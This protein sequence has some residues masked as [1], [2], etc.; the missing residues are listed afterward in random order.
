MGQEHLVTRDRK[1]LGVLLEGLVSRDL[2]EI[3]GTLV[4]P[5]RW[6][7][8]DQ[9]EPPVSR[10]V[11]ETTETRVWL[12]RR[13]YQDLKVNLVLSDQQD[14]PVT[15]GLLVQ[16]AS[17]VPWVLQGLP[18]QLVLQGHRVRLDHRVT[19]VEGDN[20]VHQEALVLSVS[21]VN[22]APRVR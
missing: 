19:Q 11:Q 20:L 5:D 13:V 3:E 7:V 16:Q 2:Q 6:V 4:L 1:V 14:S 8:Q 15:R 10:V 21:L 18:D 9:Q 17:L 12:V 22:Q